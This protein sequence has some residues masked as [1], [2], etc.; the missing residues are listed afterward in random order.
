MSRFCPVE[1][2]RDRVITHEINGDLKPMTAFP[3][4]LIPTAAQAGR[5]PVLYLGGW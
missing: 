5:M 4:Q 1:V 3:A 2:T